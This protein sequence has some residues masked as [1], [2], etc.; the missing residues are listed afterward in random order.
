MRGQQK[1][2]RDGDMVSHKGKTCL[3]PGGYNDGGDGTWLTSL[4]RYCIL[5]SKKC[6]GIF[7]KTMFR[8]VEGTGNQKVCLAAPGGRQS[9]CAKD[10]LTDSKHMRMPAQRKGR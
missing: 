1:A 8:D 10:D 4:P 2:K 7:N 6:L 9:L 3:S 5:H